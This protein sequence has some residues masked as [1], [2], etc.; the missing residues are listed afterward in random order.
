MFI[1]VTT[2]PGV[3]S[4]K[5]KK[6]KKHFRKLRNLD[7]RFKIE[8]LTMTC[9]VL[10]RTMKLQNYDDNRLQNYELLDNGTTK[11]IYN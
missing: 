5:Q 6:K 9:R 1:M 8:L 11:F 3:S 10:C 7:E 2:K 4:Q